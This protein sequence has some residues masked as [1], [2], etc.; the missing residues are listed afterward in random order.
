MKYNTSQAVS[1]IIPLLLMI[2]YF[3]VVGW[4]TDTFC[5]FILLSGLYYTATQGGAYATPVIIGA[6]S[7]IY[8]WMG[9]WYHMKYGQYRSTPESVNRLLTIRRQVLSTAID[10]LRQ[11]TYSTSK[12]LLE[13]I[14]VY[15][16]I[17]YSKTPLVNWRP[18]SVR[19]A[20]YLGGINNTS[21]DGV[22]DM[23]KGIQLALAQGARTFVFDID[24]LDESPCAPVI[25]NRDENGYMRSLHTGSIR[26]GCK[27]L[28]EK[29]FTENFDPVIVVIY[30]RRIPTSTSQSKSYLSA[31][32]M[33]LD[34]L[35]ANH[36]GSNEQGNF[37]NCRSEAL[38]FTSPIT[39]F[40]KKF[41]ILTNYD[42]TSLPQVS[43]PKDSLDFWTNARLYRDPSGLSSSLGDVT[44]APPPSPPAYAQ[45]G[46]AKQ[47]INIG[48][49]D[50]KAFIQGTTSASANTFKIALGPV[51]YTYTTAELNILLNQ[52][53]IQ[54][55]PMDVIGLSALPEH[56]RT[57]NTIQEPQ[58]AN[59]S[60]YTNDKDPLSFWTYGGW[61]RKLLTDEP[62]TNQLL[63]SPIQG[64]IIPSAVAPTA[65]SIKTNSNGGLVSIA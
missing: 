12:R 56:Q 46:D 38:L 30:M 34:P 43:N 44:P 8:F 36:L 13:K 31:I 49:A 29:A 47:F 61:S 64:Y 21:Y 4:Q 32:A 26:E 41:I 59:L 50:Q 28:A 20:G 10:P 35:S 40:Q 16:Q 6:L 52:L 54:C 2:I 39:N 33:A 7:I 19:L 53:G 5:F 1:Y 51:N 25:I 18:L 27:T 37:H 62:T 3:S 15:S 48:K 57:L 9:I 45:V 22:F 65:P 11:T 17:P 42:T 60:L 55:V 24:Y 58:L 23:T 14:G 63:L